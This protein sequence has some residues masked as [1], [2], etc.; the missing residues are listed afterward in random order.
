M[1]NRT[2]Y[3]VLGKWAIIGLVLITTSKMAMASPLIFQSVNTGQGHAC[4]VTPTGT[5]YCWGRGFSG[6]LGDGL[7]VSHNEPVAVLGGLNFQSVVAGGS[8]SCG[9]TTAGAAYCW[10]G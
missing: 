2:N 10:G 1:K 7:A 8:H 4:G 6:Q 3:S 9:L 5:A